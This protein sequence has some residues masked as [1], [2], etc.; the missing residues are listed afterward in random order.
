MRTYTTLMHVLE[1]SASAV[2]GRRLNIFLSNEHA[3]TFIKSQCQPWLAEAGDL[4]TK[5]YRGVLLHN[6]QD[7]PFQMPIRADRRSRDNKRETTSALNAAIAEKG[8]VANRSNSIFCTGAL[9]TAASY[10]LPHVVIP[11]GK[12]N[13]T[14][15][16]VME[17]AFSALSY[18]SEDNHFAYFLLPMLASK[19]LHS[20]AEEFLSDRSVRGVLEVENILP[21]DTGRMQRLVRRSRMLRDRLKTVGSKYPDIVSRFARYRGDDGSLRRAIQ[22]NHEILISG[23]SAVYVPTHAISSIRKLL[24]T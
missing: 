18:K 2:S 19:K 6:K 12:F 13:Y 1:N 16:P 9:E 4:A 8:L 7:L 15:S 17:D 3:A 10:G 23:Q 14:W 21:S 20:W 5:M 22:S 24:S 11:I